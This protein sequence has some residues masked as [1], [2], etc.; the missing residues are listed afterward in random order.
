M[1]YANV[2]IPRHE[3]MT[4]IYSVPR[5]LELKEGDVVEIELRK[6][7]IWGLVESFSDKLPEGVKEKSIKPVLGKIIETS[8][9]SSPPQT[10]F[11]KWVAEYYRYPFNKIVKQVFSPLINSKNELCGESDP[12]KHLSS[13]VK[14]NGIE[15]IDLNKDQK[16]AIDSIKSRWAEKNF[17]PTL[18]Y[19]VTGSGKSEV[20]AE[21]SREVIKSGRQVLYL[22]P[23]IGLT[24]QAMIHLIKRVGYSGVI[25]HSF[26]SPKKR[27]SSLYSAMHRQAGLIVGT[28]SSILYP[29][30]EPGLII[31]DEEHDSSYK[32]FEAPYYHARDAAIMKA[33]LLNIPVILGS[34]TP[35]SDSWLNVLN[36]K[37]QIETL[38]QRAN[39]KPLPEIKQFKFKGELYIPS[40]LVDFI[41]NSVK[42]NEQTLFFLNRRG[43]ATFPVCSECNEPVTCPNCSTALVFHKK[44]NR[45]VCHHCSFN[46]ATEICDNCKN[47]GLQFEGIGIEKLK[48][49]LEQYFPGTEILS[50][51]KDSLSTP[52]LFEKAVKS[53][54]D[55]KQ[56]IIVGT[57]MISK[58]HNFPDLRNVVIKHADYLLSFRDARAAEKCFQI[59]T[60]VAGRAG[61][62]DESGSVWAETLSPEHY[63]WKYVP[64]HDYPGFMKEELS[65]RK[66]LMLP[67]Y[68]R[69]TIVK[70]VGSAEKK[71][72]EDALSV[73][74][75]FEQI[76]EKKNI[77]N[78]VIYPPE[79]PP[80]SKVRNKFRMNITIISPKTV[81]GQKNLH[82]F[83][84]SVPCLKGSSILYDIDAINET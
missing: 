57:V 38:P 26:M 74:E 61:R 59:I 36:G 48:E 39:G 12:M 67:P 15:K 80:L 64:T 25:L 19:G 58:G 43:F 24:N 17:V 18:V 51:D 56:H 42:K 45:L 62:F 16:K 73:Y 50:F 33:S 69:M 3:N 53:I 13:V 37:Y 31:V 65:W 9:F 66:Q 46:K 27:F 81:K 83:L 23:E 30:I 63:I 7:K 47:E 75:R 22:V 82:L 6:V 32:N 28:R 10:T 79:E 8:I 68:T 1:I 55:G 4:F 41:R 70:I 49:A 60:Q 72:K 11:L 35:S 14:Y 76:R 71:V 77:E 2:L 29:F 54:S 84:D 44:K 20:F 40:N 34:A 78:I 5:F 52:S 21:L